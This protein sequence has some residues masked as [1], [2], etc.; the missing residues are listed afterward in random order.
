MQVLIIGGGLGG[1]ALA[2]GLR[3]AGFGVVVYERDVDLSATGGYHITLD[4][5]AQD[6]LAALVPERAMRQIRASAAL[7]R[8]RGDDVMWDWRGRQ[9][10]VLPDVVHPDAIDI[11]RITLRLILSEAV[12]ADLRRGAECV[13]VG[14]HDGAVVATFADGSTARG[15]ILV[16]ADGAHSIVA[17]LLAGTSP[18]RPTGIVGTSGRTAI[19]DLSPSE[20]ERLGVRSSFAI[21]PRGTALY[22]GYLD[23]A[24]HAARDDPE[25]SRA[26]T[27]EP[28]FIWGAMF[29]DTPDTDRW[30]NLSGS[31]VRDAS[32]ALLQKRGWNRA[33]LELLEKTA[34]ETVAVY[35]FNAAAAD[36]SRLAPWEPGRITA[37]GDAVHSTPPTAG[38]GA[39]IAIR[40]AEHLV[41][42]LSS[43]REGRPLD[44][45]I[46]EYE[47]EMAVRGAQAITLAMKTVRQVLATDSMLGSAMLRVSIPA[48]AALQR[49][50]TRAGG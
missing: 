17:R 26:V 45:A 13:A 44:D 32:L 34:S 43:V 14:P 16:G 4:P 47:R 3:R 36:A 7:A 24:G 31:G 49:L 21:G 10:A 9:L 8:R 23:P 39:G 35:R 11:D 28:S 6:A 27:R 48:M 20:R 19:S 38:M 41:R 1:L 37:L 12:G 2:A 50:R 22:A 29:P 30:R 18:T 25:E 42:A 5:R 15:D 46:G 40:D 33:R